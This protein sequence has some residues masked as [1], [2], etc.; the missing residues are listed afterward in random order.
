MYTYTYY[1]RGTLWK[2]ERCISEYVC[3]RDCKHVCTHIQTHPYIYQQYWK[4]PTQILKESYTTP[5]TQYHPRSPINQETVSPRPLK[6]P[7]PPAPPPQRGRG[8]GG[9]N[10]NS[11]ATDPPR[12]SHQLF[13]PFDWATRDL[14]SF[15]SHGMTMCVCCFVLLN[16]YWGIVTV[17]GFLHER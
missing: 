9:A 14:K 1:M 6:L 5:P 2:S 17:P 16:R 3:Q 10:K 12:P 11:G 15:W 4:S 7:T 8:G 13:Y